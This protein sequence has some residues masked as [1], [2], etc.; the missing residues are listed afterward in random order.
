VELKL[1]SLMISG[2]IVLTMV[3]S[4]I[5]KEIAREIKS[6]PI[7]LVFSDAAMRQPSGS[8]KSRNQNF[9]AHALQ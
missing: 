7:H 3:P 2:K 6:R 9:L 5:T 1:K 4:M 8:E